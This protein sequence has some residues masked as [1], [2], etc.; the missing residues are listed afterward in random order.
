LLDE[1]F[2]EFVHH[3]N[4]AAFAVGD[5]VE[6]VFEFGGEGIVGGLGVNTAAFLLVA[7]D[8]K[9]LSSSVT[10]CFVCKTPKTLSSPRLLSETKC[11]GLM[12]THRRIFRAYSSPAEDTPWVH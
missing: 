4:P 9:T 1:R 12:L 11:D 5:F 7:V 3:R 2:P 6:L 10:G 8:T